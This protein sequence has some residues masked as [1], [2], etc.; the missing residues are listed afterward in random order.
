MAQFGSLK[1]KDIS[2]GLHSIAIGA[3]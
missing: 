1:G 3:L 2:F